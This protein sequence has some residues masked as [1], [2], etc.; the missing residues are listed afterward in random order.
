MPK[1]KTLEDAFLE[2]RK[3][4][5]YA[6][7][8]AGRR[9]SAAVEEKADHGGVS[10]RGGAAMVVAAPVFTS[11]LRGWERRSRTPA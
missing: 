7:K 11:P 4:G 1:A 9:T 6:E 2:T 8:Q 3:D 10:D 5:Y